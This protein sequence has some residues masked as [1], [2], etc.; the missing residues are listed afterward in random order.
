M[1]PDNMAPHSERLESSVLPL[2]L[3]LL[4]HR[5]YENY[6]LSKYLDHTVIKQIRSSQYLVKMRIVN[7]YSYNKTKEM[8]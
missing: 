2:L 3:L 6:K 7:S 1:G 5:Q 8:H 4:Q